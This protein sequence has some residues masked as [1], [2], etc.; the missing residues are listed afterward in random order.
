MYTPLRPT[1]S[2]ALLSRHRIILKTSEKQK[3]VMNKFFVASLRFSLT[4][5]LNPMEEAT[6]VIVE[7]L[8]TVSLEGVEKRCAARWNSL[9]NCLIHPETMSSKSRT[10]VT[11]IGFFR[12]MKFISRIGGRSTEEITAAGYEYILKNKALQ[13]WEFVYERLRHLQAQNH[14]D[15][16]TDVVTLLFKLAYCEYGKWYTSDNLT[17]EQKKLM[18][19]FAS[20]GIVFQE[21]GGA[22]FPTKTAIS[23][24]YESTGLYGRAPS[25][26][27][28]DLGVG[29]SHGANDGGAMDMSDSQLKLITETTFQVTAYVE[30]DLH[31]E[32][33]QL[34]ME[35][36]MRM[37]GMV[38]GRITR[39]RTHDAFKKNITA[40]QILDF[41]HMYAHELCRANEH[42]VP[43]NVCDQIVLWENETKRINAESAVI[44]SVRELFEP[45]EILPAYKAMLKKANDFGCLLWCNDDKKKMAIKA[46]FAAELERSLTE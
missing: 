43:S 8:K 41:L 24:L 22:F 21:K 46:S 26:S 30:S 27:Q 33:L 25:K 37:P 7:K 15:D 32:M 31:F 44:Y 38:S 17:V 40:V 3:Y 36:E 29:S 35:I 45:E 34:F 12:R 42:V 18:A 1:H 39:E 23:M 4:S 19:E 10:D 13:I 9:L 20:L 5:A 28:G 6:S 2:L 11:A 16:A 14:P